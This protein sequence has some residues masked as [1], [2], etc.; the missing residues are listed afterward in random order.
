MECEAMQAD[1]R[2]PSP[3][4]SS[5]KIIR[6]N[7]RKKKNPMPKVQPKHKEQGDPLQMDTDI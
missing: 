4:M 1:Q 6:K 3:R 2:V 7:T 5:K